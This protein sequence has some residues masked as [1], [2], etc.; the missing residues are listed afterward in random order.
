M[1]DYTSQF[2]G[3]EIDA[4]LAKVPQLESAVD[5]KQATLVSGTNIKTINGESVL[6]SGNIVAGDPN[7]VKYTE[8][9]LTDAQKAQARSNINAASIADISAFSDMEYIVAWDGTDTPVVANIP[10]GVSVTY[11]TTTYTGTLAASASTAGNVY[12][13]KNG[14]N[15][16]MYVSTPDGS[17]YS[18][19]GIGSTS[20]DLSGYATKSELN[21]LDLK[22][23]KVSAPS[24]YRI[25]DWLGS[26]GT[27]WFDTG[28]AGGTN[29][30]SIEG[31]FYYDKFPGGTSWAYFYGNY[32]GSGRSYQAAIKFDSETKVYV[33]IS[34]NAGIANGP[35]SPRKWFHLLAQ[36]S[37]EL[38]IDGIQATGASANATSASGNIALMQNSV[39]TQDGKDGGVRVRTFRVWVSGVLSLDMV[40]MLREYDRKPGMYDLLSKTFYTSDGTGEFSWSLGE[41]ATQ[42]ELAETDKETEGANYSLGKFAV[43]RIPADNGVGGITSTTGIELSGINGTAIPFDP[44]RD[45]YYEAVAAPAS[46][47]N[48]KILYMNCQVNNLAKFFGFRF[49]NGNLQFAADPFLTAI[50]GNGGMQF[51][52][53]YHIMFVVVSSKYYLYVDG[54][55]KASGDITGTLA[56]PNG[57]TVVQTNSESS[58][59]LLRTGY[60]PT[61]MSKDELVAEHLNGGNPFAFVAPKDTTYVEFLPSGMTKTSFTNNQNGQVTTWAEKNYTIQDGGPWAAELT[62]TG[63]PVVIPRYKGQRYRDTGTGRIY[64][65]IGNTSASDWQYIAVSGDIAALKSQTK[66]VDG[67]SIWGSGDIETGGGG[68]GSTFVSVKDK[69]AVGD[70]LTD[71]TDAIMS[72]TEYARANGKALYFPVGE[73]LTRKSIVLTSGMRVTGEPGATLTN[74]SAIL[75]G[76]G[77]CVFSTTTAN[78]SAGAHSVSVSDA[79]K[80]TVGDEIVI[81]KT[82]SYTETMADI[83]DITGNTITFSTERFTADGT[84]GG[85]LNAVAS[86]GYVLTDFAMIKTIM[87]KAA[88]DVTVENITIKPLSDMNEP[89]IYTSSPISQT[90]QAG[91]AQ[92]G[93]RVHDVTVLASA[94]DGISLQGTGD[95]EVV[96]CRVYG[97]KHK[98]VHW[99]TSHDKIRI[100][101]CLLYEC[102]SQAYD[103]PGDYYGSGALFF[104]VN[105]HRV[106]IVNNQI[107]KCYRGVYG[108]NYI[109][110]GSQDSDTVI[111]GNIF[112][113]CGKYGILMQGGYGAVISDNIFIDFDN[114]AIPIR[115]ENE[116]TFKFTAGIISGNLFRNFGSSF[117]GPAIQVTGSRELVITGNNVSG[118]VNNDSATIRSHCDITVASSEKVI[119]ANNIVDGTIDTTDAGNTGIVKDNNIETS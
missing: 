86:G 100:E 25:L 7:A 29:N 64:T 71:D 19:I 17:S 89:H 96:G 70:G 24:G 10:A 88:V 75:N 66:T 33:A 111:S 59:K 84:D 26:D 8:Q 92:R 14:A 49:N 108:F 34:S 50:A 87:T 77:K 11:N 82:G 38:Y 41:F 46:G 30:I 61:G 81:W 69:G 4:R 48:K 13:V 40:P 83:T 76:G 114:A 12:L 95:S 27:A 21:E 101:G 2:S 68:G 55:Q 104:C 65:A 107:E 15:Y 18:W 57:L 94:N 32:P 119:V 36:S 67:Q 54:V 39:S 60:I 44:S 58:P 99:G 98:G 9:T 113:N 43:P 45:H 16:D 53:L 105:N 5:G 23:N 97:Q 31:D 62:G 91:E 72:A 47:S 109:D 37:G 35:I 3:S 74:A 110:N 52:T 115:T 51:G 118:Y 6:G 63:V 106:I 78:A 85:L 116:S 102:G 79:S 56:V 117:A 22:V 28:I 1:A 73:Y 93:F 90:K 112:K 80:F 103:N 42:T 20:L